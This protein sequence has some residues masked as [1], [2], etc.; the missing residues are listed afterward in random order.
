MGATQTDRRAERP[1]GSHSTVPLKRGGVAGRRGGRHARPHK[2]SWLCTVYSGVY[3]RSTLDGHSICGARVAQ[4]TER[5]GPR[6]T[7]G[8][9]F[10][11]RAS[12]VFL[13]SI[14]NRHA[15]CNHVSA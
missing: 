6:G 12:D 7:G 3:E 8:A 9:L 11:A 13:V 1:P 14:M 15:R 5:E 4:L 10:T 2:Q